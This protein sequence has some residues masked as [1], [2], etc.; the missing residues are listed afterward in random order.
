M[1]PIKRTRSDVLDSLAKEIATAIAKRTAEAYSVEQIEGSE[2]Y[3]PV[4]YNQASTTDYQRSPGAER[5]AR[6]VRD[7]EHKELS[8]NQII[9]RT[10]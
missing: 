2:A 9:D 5:R 4:P 10:Q 6:I 8:E 7:D 3:E 1:N